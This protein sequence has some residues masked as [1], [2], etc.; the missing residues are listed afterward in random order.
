MEHSQF[1]EPVYFVPGV[2]GKA[3]TI[4]DVAVLDADGSL[5]GRFS[6]ETLA[7]LRCRHPGAELG[8]LEE[9]VAAQEKAL[10]TEPEE[11]SE[12]EYIRMLEVLP[13]EDWRSAGGMES[14]K[15]M[16]RFSGRIT[17]IFV[18]AG[19]KYYTFKD[20]CTMPHAN[21][22]AKVQRHLAARSQ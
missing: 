13:P 19:Q 15:L 12:E 5:R 3:S 6:K 11:I 2:Q 17:N 14:F 10:T 20:V 7:Q 21:I 4:V 8:E 18:R 1:R 9:V 22:A 16:E